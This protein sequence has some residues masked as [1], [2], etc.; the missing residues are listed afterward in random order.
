MNISPCEHKSGQ[1]LQAVRQ[2][3]NWLPETFYTRFPVSVNSLYGAVCPHLSSAL[4]KF[5]CL[6]AKK[7]WLNQLWSYFLV[8][9]PRL[10]LNDGITARGCAWMSPKET[11]LVFVQCFYTDV[12]KTWASN[13][14][15]R[16][17]RRTSTSQD[18][19]ALRQVRW[20]DFST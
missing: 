16:P 7:S 10:D 14:R 4:S 8:K 1:M 6:A 20:P 19:F 17:L 2:S 11:V 5:K 3:L 12:P 18:R 13:F 9:C 15:N